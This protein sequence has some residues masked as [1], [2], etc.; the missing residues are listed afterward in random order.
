MPTVPDKIQ[1]IFNYLRVKFPDNSL[2]RTYDSQHGTEI[3]ILHHKNQKILIAISKEFLK[4]TPFDKIE[5]ELKKYQLVE[6]I[7]QGKTQYILVTTSGLKLE[8]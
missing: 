8:K 3:F 2:G 4:D 6:V 7:K 1:E 5:A